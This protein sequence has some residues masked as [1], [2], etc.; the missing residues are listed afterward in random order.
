MRP[1]LS[2]PP[3]KESAIAP[4]PPK[5][6]GIAERSK[7][8][9]I[10]KCL[11]IVLMLFGSLT[12]ME[13]QTGPSLPNAPAVSANASFETEQSL[14]F[15]FSG[16]VPT[17][18][19]STTELQLSLRDAV[20]RGLRSNLGILLSTDVTSDARADRLRA[21]SALLPHVTTETS[22][23]VH[24]LEPRTTIGLRLPGVKPVVGPFGVFDT[25][26]HWKQNVFN[27]E[28]IERM[29]ASGEQAR[30]ANFNYRDAHDLVVLAVA[31]SYL[32]AIADQSRV[33]SAQAQRDTANALYRQTLDQKKAGIAAAIDVLRSEVELEQRE[34]ELILARNDLAKEK[35]VL[36]RTIGLPAGQ[37]FA[38]ITDVAFEALPDLTL[39]DALSNA[40][41]QRSD[42]RSAMASVHAAELTKAATRAERYP[43]IT[44]VADYGDIGVNPATSH[45][46][47]NAAAQLK[48]PVFQGGEVHADKLHADALVSR[49]RQTLGNLRGQIDQDVRDAF[50]DLASS[51]DRVAVE[52]SATEL[53][54]QTLQQARDRF[55]SGV[56]DNIEIVQAQEALAT[57][58]E[59]YIASLYSFNVSKLDLA[60]AIGD[61][62]FGFENYLKGVGQ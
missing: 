31:S 32:L 22:L 18:A 42:L 40:Y 7:T 24:Q 29:R 21:L 46:T 62:E 25:R 5:A 58:Q 19:V 44:A 12:T 33:S 37:A 47:V 2:E 17:G 13:A 9:L 48:I 16:S 8:L 59:S 14:H 45:G 10:T 15:P 50:L 1:D 4:G 55:A 60:R 41:A 43:S 56:T 3:I 23:A 34:Q 28:D 26:A 54:N 35:L 57:A 30:A 20:E 39:N 11:S 27:W 6:G 51:R 49:A 52:K 53:A 38:L 36:A 61:S